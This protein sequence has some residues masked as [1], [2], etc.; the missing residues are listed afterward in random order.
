MDLLLL[1]YAKKKV[2][3]LYNFNSHVILNCSAEK[4]TISSNISVLI[5]VGLGDRGKEDFRLAYET[6]S[7]LLKLVPDRIKSDSLT[8]PLR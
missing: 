2:I 7:A 8:P 1:V 3:F 5:S 4:L 6:C